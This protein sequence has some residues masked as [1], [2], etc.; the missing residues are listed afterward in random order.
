MIKRLF[1]SFKWSLLVS[2]IICIPYLIASFIIPFHA[3]DEVQMAGFWFI[4]FFFLVGLIAILMLTVW[5]FKWLFTG[6][7]LF[8]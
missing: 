6:K 8:E 5:Y 1:E 7:D 2:S 4:G 3:K